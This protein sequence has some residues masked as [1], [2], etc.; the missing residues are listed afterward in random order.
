[1]NPTS[2]LPEERQSI[3]Q[4]GGGGLPRLLTSTALHRALTLSEHLAIHGELAPSRRRGRETGLIAEIDH[5][6]LRGRGGAGFPTGRKMRAVAASRRRPIVVLNAT[7]GEPASLKDA[8]LATTVPHL[9]LDGAVLAARALGADE[10]LVAV[11]ERAPE[12]VDALAVAIAERGSDR[13]GPRLSLRQ[14]PAGYLTGQESALIS[15]LDGGPGLPRF[16]PPMPF[17]RGVG[18]RPTMVSNAE[19]YA[20]IGMI[21]RHGADWFR[22]LGTPAEPGSALVTI[23]GVV[24]EPGVYEIEWGTKLRALVRAAGGL[25]A[26][27]RA[28]LL[29]G[30]GGTWVGAE[31]LAE[32]SLSDE[33]LAPH[34]ASLG[35]GVVVLLDGAACPVAETARV[36]RWMADQ[37]ARQCGPCLHGLH[38]LATEFEQ[39]TYGSSG[40][41]H[42]QRLTRLAQ[43]VQGRGACAHPDGVTRLALS[44]LDTF[45]DEF[46]DHATHGGCE[47]CTAPARLPLPAIQR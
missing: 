1:M 41:E 4:S 44:A 11:C 9:A 25:T 22:E 21:C 32:L 43:M 8:T 29:G 28:A 37:S 31:H 36:I 19:T 39:L 12:S 38:A 40:P 45:T 26:A 35:A 30:Y 16:T 14:I 15:H 42:P 18:G 34:G 23:S 20:H 3:P 7:E 13:H 5:A 47:A 27:P 10:V 46:R 6:G 17:E 2:T 33:A 24:A